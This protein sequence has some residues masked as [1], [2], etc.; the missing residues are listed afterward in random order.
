MID[1]HTHLLPRV[2]DGS[3][4]TEESV[5]VLTLMAQRRVTA[6]LL[7]PHVSASQLEADPDEPLGLRQRSYEEL[8]A[9]APPT[10]QLHLGFEVMLD[11]PMPA[12]VMGDR[13]ISLAGSRYYL[14]EFPLGVV[15]DFATTVLSQ[16]T[17]SGSVP[18]VA[19]AERYD[20][21][22]VPTV[23]DWRD[24]G[25]K[26]QV[27]ATTLTRPGTRGRRARDLLE[28]GLADVIAS[29]NHGGR[30]TVATGHDY[31]T[32]LGYQTVAERL[33]LENPR[34]VLEDAE[35]LDVPAVKIEEGMLARIKRV[36]E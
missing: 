19:H 27:D 6:V 24:V 21:C 30:R 14:V 35:M 10:P 26:I 3:D 34:A 18:L 33:T 22:S 4:S 25:A 5:K 28:A 7:T 17:R 11:R 8:R 29:D 36:F 23:S 16:I 1:L 32:Q 9:Y 13:R 15:A 12:L 31:L 2:D 20:A